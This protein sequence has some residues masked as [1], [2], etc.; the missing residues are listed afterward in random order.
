MQNTNST[1]DELDAVLVGYEYRGDVGM[2]H[3]S[4]SLRSAG[5]RAV[6]VP[7]STDPDRLMDLVRLV[8]HRRPRL[9]CFSLVF[10]SMAPDV[11]GAIAVVRA[12]GV[13]QHIAME[14]HYP[15]FACA[16]MLATIPDLD[17]IV[18]CAGTR[19]LRELLTC[20]ADDCDWRFI[21]GL[22]HR[23]RSVPER[24]RA[25]ARSARATRDTRPLPAMAIPG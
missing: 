3:L 9:V 23:C 21:D 14:A 5:V 6:F 4:M 1:H 20:L 11:A 15:S 12:L 19:A 13:V 7:G 24:D 8:Q 17:S 22:A 10:P 18:R 16:A 2:R 25:A